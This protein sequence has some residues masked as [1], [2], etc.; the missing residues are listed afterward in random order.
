LRIRAGLWAA[1]ALVP[2]DRMMFE[3]AHVV[4]GETPPRATVMHVWDMH[5]KSPGR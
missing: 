1:L 3:L 4:S 5:A 2:A